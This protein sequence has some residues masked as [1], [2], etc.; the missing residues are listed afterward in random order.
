MG[1]A[2]NAANG[3]IVS[4]GLRTSI[5]N[6]PPQYADRQKQYFGE[7][8]ARF[9]EKYARYTTD[10]VTARVQGLCPGAPESWQTTRVR[11]ADIAPGG[12]STLRKLDDYKILLFEDASI[13]YIR[14]GSKIETMGSTWLVINPQNISGAVGVTIVQRC[15]TVYNRLDW[16]G[17]VIS[18]PICFEKALAMA[19]GGD[20]QEYAIITQGYYNIRC[21]KNDVTAEL[22]TNSRMILGKGAYHLTGVT[23][24]LREFTDDEDSARIM[25][26]TARYEPPNA[27]IDDLARHVAGGK[28]FAWE[29]LLH[30]EP[31]IRAGQTMKLSTANRRC[32]EYVTGTAERPIDYFWRSS[33][34]EVASVAADGTIT[35][36]SSGDVTITCMLAQNPEITAEY[37]LRVDAQGQAP[38][39]IFTG[40][41]PKT[42]SA[43]ESATLT[44]VYFDENG[45]TDE[46]VAFSFAGPA[47]E[48]YTA[49]ISGNSVTITCWSGATKPLVVTAACAGVRAEKEIELEGI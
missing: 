17:N 5:K 34:E 48:A 40:N 29:I 26:F 18:E 22:D 41:V 8:A 12:I 39:V 24:F 1:L 16:Y 47:A 2:E 27:E 30:G 13:D 31:E 4:G 36:I 23:D 19:N 45:E 6:T 9:V 44:A 14:P 37:R 35:G 20:M 49:D 10:F 32:G 33:D 46:A 28:T 3:M 42:L 7:A 43:F 21:Q 15:S 38:E 25:E 11:L